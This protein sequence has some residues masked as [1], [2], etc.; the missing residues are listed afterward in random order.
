MS[1]AVTDT[2]GAPR[3]TDHAMQPEPVQRSSTFAGR[4]MAAS[5]FRDSSTSCPVSGLGMSTDGATLN[6]LPQNSV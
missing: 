5:S 3:A 1:A 4:P 6:F 2:P